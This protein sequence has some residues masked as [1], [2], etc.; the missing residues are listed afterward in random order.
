MTE[1]EGIL[2]GIEN[3]LGIVS[4]RSPRGG[5]RY[6]YGAEEVVA[7]AAEARGWQ[8]DAC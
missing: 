7:G 5:L 8:D 4:G 3:S 2:R 1:Y 6:H